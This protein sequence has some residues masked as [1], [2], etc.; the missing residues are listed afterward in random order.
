MASSRVFGKSWTDKKGKKCGGWYADYTDAEGKR[1]RK[2]TGANTRADAKEFLRKKENQRDTQMGRGGSTSLEAYRDTFIERKRIQ[3][4]KD[5]NFFERRIVPLAE[6][7]QLGA[8]DLR[9]ITPQDIE[10]YR[11]IRLHTKN[12]HGR[13]YSVATI[14]RELAV[15]SSMYSEAIRDG[16][17]EINPVRNVKRKRESRR[18]PVTLSVSQFWELHEH[19]PDYMKPIVL[20]AYATG[21]RKGEIL[22]LKPE[23][24]DLRAG[25][26]HLPHG[27]TK[28][29]MARDIPLYM[30][31]NSH[32]L[33]TE[34]RKVKVPKGSDTFFTRPT[35]PNERK[36]TRGRPNSNWQPV[37]DISFSFNGAL[38]KMGLLTFA[39]DK[40]GHKTKKIVSRTLTFHN[41]R[42]LAITNMRRAG[43][44][45]VV[46]MR[47][48][49]HTTVAMHELYNEVGQD[50]W[51][52]GQDMMA[53]YMNKT[54]LIF[55][56]SHSRLESR[57]DEYLH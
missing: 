35:R 32:G 6:S 57:E 14:N 9:A 18:Q 39:R 21:M 19:C 54:T 45:Q 11:H 24:V 30:F 56:P 36:M 38:E 53:A 20:M 51:D 22:R 49:G 50:D 27:T 16:L 7:S 43:L 3:G 48:T 34:L 29:E 46:I 52:A 25:I 8:K 41:L 44:P 42:R 37:G 4:V 47:I 12:K 5:L 28:S 15:L 40:D 10:N 23:W 1:R 33:M 2:A 13:A 55:T 26:I 17:A 31:E